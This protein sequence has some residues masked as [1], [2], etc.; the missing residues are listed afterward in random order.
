MFAGFLFF[1]MISAGIV[2]I[3]GFAGLELVK[4]LSFH[5]DTVLNYIASRSDVGKKLSDIYPQFKG[6]IDITVEDIDIERIKN[7]DVLFLALPH[8]VS[9]DIAK[10]VYGNV[11]IIDL[12]ADFRLS[13][14]DTYKTWY[15][16]EH[17]AQDIL[18]EAVYGLCEINRKQ[19]KMSTL[20][21]NPGCYATSVIL[22]AAPILK[23]IDT[24]NIIADS[25]SGVSGAGRGV[26]EGLQ[27]CEVNENFK[28]YSV[29]NHRHTPE[30]EEFL[31]KISNTDVQLIFSPHLI[32]MQ[33]GIL[34]TV[35]VQ[36]KNPIDKEYLFDLYEKFY[37]NSPFVRISKG[38]PSTNNVKGSN[39]CDIG[40]EVDSRSGR[41]VIVS[42][43][44]NLIKGAS[45]Q[46]V[47]NMNIMFN[48]NE[49]EGLMPYPYY[50]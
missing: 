20:T 8:T 41:V 18:K 40:F 46:A 32:P 21:A 36:P 38:L 23:Y 43:I 5:K 19:I 14:A 48:L 27:Y 34:S 44:D 29:C 24:K 42:V 3:T 6:L 45:G 30:I 31:S 25:K 17:L 4:I 15:K 33:R 50:P 22:A 2:G 1:K 37:L 10:Q 16:K 49:T 9:M 26:K 13:N 11:K 35:Y 47:Q 12:S 39:F 7:L 28:A